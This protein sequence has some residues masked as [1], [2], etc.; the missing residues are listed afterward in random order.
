[1]QYAK[2]VPSRPPPFR[3]VKGFTDS[4]I[5]EGQT[6]P[7]TIP[8]SAL[9]AGRPFPEGARQPGWRGGGAAA[10]AAGEGGD[11]NTSRVTGEEARYTERLNAD[12]FES[13][14]EAAEVHRHVRKYAQAAIKPGMRLADFCEDLENM[15]RRLVGEAG[16][17]RGI[18]FPTGVSL[19]HV[20]AHYTPNPGD[21]T[22]LSYGDV[23]KVDF[24]T[25]VNGRIV[26]CAF[27]V[28]FDPAF[29]PLLA[30]VNAATEAG[31]AAA[32][33]D[34]RL[35]E[36]GAAIQEVMESHEVTLN[37]VTYPIKSIRNLNGH[38]IGPYNIHAG[39]SVPIVKN[40]DQTKMEEGE[41]YA[42][43][44]FG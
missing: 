24:G 29:D 27:T 6:D 36:I 26:D 20:A 13:V 31:I 19:N 30:A 5:A 14:R 37:G 4:Y 2:G 25:Q 12:M 3:G 42:I 34:A 22:V 9:F 1:M 7:P 41:L 35:G 32:G 44:T 38:S 21:D 11:L 43:E 10:A 23:M 40:G 15:N 28:A 16:L 17:A 39:K 8:I 18:A 33:V